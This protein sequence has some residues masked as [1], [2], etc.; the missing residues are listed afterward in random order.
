MTVCE[1]YIGLMTVAQTNADTIV[2]CIKYVLLCRISEFKMLV[3][4]L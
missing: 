2:I 4:V 3:A 1:E